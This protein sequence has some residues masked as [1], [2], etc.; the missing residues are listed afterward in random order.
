MTA[1]PPTPPPKLATGATA[2]R[3]ETY[4]RILGAA[5]E[6]FATRGFVG[7]GIRDIGHASG[8]KTSGLYHYMATKDDLLFD[9]IDRGLSA[10]IAASNEVVAGVTEPAPRLALLASAA[11][12]IHANYQRAYLVIDN[13][14]PR[15]QGDILKRT[16]ELRDQVDQ[17][18]GATIDDGRRKDVFSVDEPS[19]ARLSLLSMVRGVALWYNPAGSLEVPVVAAHLARLALD[20]VRTGSDLAE[21]SVPAPDSWLMQRVVHAV[22]STHAAVPR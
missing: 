2:P 5:L 10:T 4:E 22:E 11:V 8:I 3:N 18:W 9:I 17:L 15:L 14:F 19:L 16:V 21:E 7:T 20:L 12:V 6:L 13:E 1:T